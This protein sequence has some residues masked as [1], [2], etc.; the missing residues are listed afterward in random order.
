[1]GT[2]VFFLDI[3]LRPRWPGK[4]DEDDKDYV[5]DDDIWTD[6]DGSEDDQETDGDDGADSDATEIIVEESDDENMLEIKVK[7][8]M[9][10]EE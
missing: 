9:A 7:K 1:V 10:G 8:G 3:G 2:W 5:T 6:S 4:S